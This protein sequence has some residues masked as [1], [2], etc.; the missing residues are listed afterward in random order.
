MFPIVVFFIWQIL[1]IIG[2]QIEIKKI[3]SPGSIQINL[4]K[5]W[6][7]ANNF[8]KLVFV[9]ENCPNDTTTSCKVLFT[10]VGL[11]KSDLELQDEFKNFKDSF[12]Q[13]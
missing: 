11:L 7:Q 10:L 2:L 9:N 1:R 5:C 13:D 8:Q 4:R 3:F 6:L 12:E